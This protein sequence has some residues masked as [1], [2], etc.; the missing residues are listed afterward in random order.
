[1]YGQ[2]I[3]YI[4]SEWS[5]Q[6]LSKY[7]V[8]ELSVAELTQGY[9]T[10]KI[11]TMHKSSILS[12]TSEV[13]PVLF[14][15]YLLPMYCFLQMYHSIRLAIISGHT[16]HLVKTFVAAEFGPLGQSLNNMLSDMSAV[17]GTGTLLQPVSI[18]RR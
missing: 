9:D 16:F 3:L 5:E 4:L 12:W 17:W 7:S 2:R 11:Q 1:M 8:V 6:W 15:G 14:D 18:L 13:V 10:A